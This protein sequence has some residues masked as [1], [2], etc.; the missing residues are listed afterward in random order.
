MIPSEDRRER[1]DK[2]APWWAL[3]LVIFGVTGVSTT[4]VS[5]GAFWDGYVL[6]MTGPAWNYILFRRLFHQYADDAWTRFFNPRRTVVIFLAVAFG[7]EFIQYLE[8]YDSTF[9][10]WD[11]VAYV[12]LLLPLFMV[13]SVL[14]MR[15]T[16]RASR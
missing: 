10:P 16:P 1:H 3:T 12:S 14:Q 13:D 11:L 9:D 5:L 8:L 15:S 4:F 2:A 6:D 7:I